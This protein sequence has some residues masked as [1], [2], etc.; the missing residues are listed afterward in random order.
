MFKEEV[1][2]FD[3]T[4]AKGHCCKIAKLER[5]RPLWEV[6]ARMRECLEAFWLC[7]SARCV[8]TPTL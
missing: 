1:V 2:T 7:L 6:A 8:M 5:N 4:A 3:G